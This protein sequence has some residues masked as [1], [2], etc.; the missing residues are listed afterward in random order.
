ML[1]EKVF[2][3]SVSLCL[4]FKTPKLVK[5]KAYKRVRN[6]KV[7]LVRSHYRIVEGR[8]VVMNELRR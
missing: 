1:K 8:L 3:L 7:E 6:G 5:V 2:R 4:G